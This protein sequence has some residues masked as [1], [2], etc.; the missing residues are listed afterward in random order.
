MG[1]KDR[2]LVVFPY[3]ERGVIYIE[4][5]ILPLMPYLKKTSPTIFES[6]TCEIKVCSLSLENNMRGMRADLV[7]LS[8]ECSLKTYNDII[9]PMVNRDHKRVKVVL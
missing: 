8:D 9:L 3:I 7:F 6:D 5:N 4:E 1:K 2:F